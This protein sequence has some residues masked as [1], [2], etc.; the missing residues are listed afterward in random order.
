[1]HLYWLLIHV[2]VDHYKWKNAKCDNEKNL[3]KNAYDIWITVLKAMKN[4]LFIDYLLFIEL[5]GF[6]QHYLA[7][8]IK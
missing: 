5:I 7:E 4:N 8:E 1:V 6:I 3:I 2:G